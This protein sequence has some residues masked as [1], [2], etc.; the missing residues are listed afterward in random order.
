MDEINDFH[1]GFKKCKFQSDFLWQSCLSLMYGFQSCTEK[2][3]KKLKSV[4]NQSAISIYT[5][6]FGANLTRLPL[7]ENPTS[8]LSTL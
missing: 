3:Q 8:N 2:V 1:F 6:Q 4:F 7:K 5:R